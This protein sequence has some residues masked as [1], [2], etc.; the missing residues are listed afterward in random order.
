MQSI[1]KLSTAIALLALSMVIGVISVRGDSSTP[2]NYISVNF[3][4]I[5]T[6]QSYTYDFATGTIS[7][8]T[9]TATVF[10]TLNLFQN[11][12]NADPPSSTPNGYGTFIGT[13]QPVTYSGGAVL[14]EQSV[15]GSGYPTC[16]SDGT[17]TF[18]AFV[19][20]NTRGLMLDQL[21]NLQTMYNVQSGCF[22]CGSPRFQIGM[23]DG[24]NIF[25]YFGTYPEFADCPTSNTW[26][27]TG[28]FASDSAG[29]RWDTSQICP[30][31]QY[32]DY[33]GA[34]TCADS[35]GLTINAISIVT[36]GGWFGTN[37]GSSN[38]QTFLFQQIQLN[39]VT[40]FP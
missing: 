30:G 22:G 12:I 38:G 40:R 10:S 26:S 34:I 1:R 15:C 35:F 27:S 19:T 24:K 32:N 17:F 3:S 36:D 39:G 33:T 37:A 14:Y 25:V 16:F 7:A 11:T 21:T 5:T 29:L 28:Q 6:T 9:A 31:T 2:V 8:S 23:S 20:Y 18:A 13:A 4:P